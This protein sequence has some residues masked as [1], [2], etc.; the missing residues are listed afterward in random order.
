MGLRKRAKQGAL[1]EVG[2][3]TLLP[4][5]LQA[6]KHREWMFLYS[7]DGD[8]HGAR[9]A[10]FGNGDVEW[11]N[12]DWPESLGRKGKKL[13]DPEENMAALKGLGVGKEFRVDGLALDEKGRTYVLEAKLAP[14]GKVAISSAK[15]AAELITQSLRYCTRILQGL[16]GAKG[17]KES[18]YEFL[19]LLHH[20]HWVATGRQYR[21]GG[22]RGLAA[23]HAWFFGREGREK[24]KSAFCA[25]PRVVF[26]IAGRFKLRPLL[27]QLQ[28]LRDHAH[29]KGAYLEAVGFAT[30]HTKVLREDVDEAMWTTLATEVEFS[31]VEVNTGA[32]QG[33]LGVNR[34]VLLP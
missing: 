25:V 23:H 10:S 17:A 4:Q 13:R 16:K 9:S 30:G 28:I 32:L 33:V 1:H 34:S 14:E 22:Y 7:G 21:Y 12:C 26:M 19:D 15:D 18:G 3:T 6:T 11:L 5:L 29:D 27:E 8:V 24:S 31:V 2:F 20:L